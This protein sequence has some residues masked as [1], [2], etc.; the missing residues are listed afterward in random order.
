M[1]TWMLYELFFDEIH[2]F[3]CSKMPVMK[4]HF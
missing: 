2:V 3:I 1:F 4:E